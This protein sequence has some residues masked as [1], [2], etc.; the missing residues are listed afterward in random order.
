MN[1]RFIISI[2]ALSVAIMGATYYT[3]SVSSTDV[4]LLIDETDPQIS[5]PEAHQILEIFGLGTNAWNGA[6]FEAR[7]ITD[8]DYTKAYSVSIPAVS[9]LDRQLSN[10]IARRK[11]V[12]DFSKGTV[13]ILD[14][15]KKD[16]IGKRH[17]SVYR[18]IVT[19]LNDVA[20]EN[21]ASRKIVLV[22]SDLRENSSVLN[23]Y[24]SNT[25]TLLKTNPDSIAN[26]FQKQVA[27]GNLTG[28][29]VFLVYEPSQYID[30]ESYRLISGLYQ[31]MLEG[32]G[33]KVTIAANLNF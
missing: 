13:A 30:N 11:S 15:L 23:L 9:F 20:T 21:L 2:L 29:E 8:I 6:Y 27:I 32:K 5:Q 22:Y 24:D 18:V 26:I 28:V 12:E 31:N 7:S 1:Y 19:E 33:A 16:S 3:Y 10:D 25:L 4:R 14:T 17:S